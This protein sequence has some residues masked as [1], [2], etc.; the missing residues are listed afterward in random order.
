MFKIDVLTTRAALDAL[1]PEWSEMAE[2]SGRP[3]LSHQWFAAAA[4]AFAADGDLRIFLA[5]EGGAIR[6]AA[7]LVVDR[8]GGVKRLRLLGFQT[9]EPEALP[10]TDRAALDAVC[11]AALRGGC[12]VSLPRVTDP[13]TLQALQGAASRGVQITRPET[14]RTY[15][16]ILGGDPAALERAMAKKK[17]G[18]IRRR[19]KRLAEEFG[20]VGFHAESPDAAGA[21]AA[22]A[23]LLEAEAS[24]WKG[25]AGSSVL[26]DAAMGGFIT[27][28]ARRAAGA[29]LLR[30]F[31][32][33]VA[34]EVAAGHMMVE[35]GGKLWAIKLGAHQR[36]LRLGAGVMVTHEVLRW[37]C[38]HGLEAVDH[39]GVAETWQERWPL[40]AT[41]QS[42]FHFYPRTPAGAAALTVD[43]LAFAR[44]RLES[45]AEAR[46][47]AA[48]ASAGP[49][50]ELVPA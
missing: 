16:N 21:D 47:G 31:T 45:R 38:E 41:A 18:D 2:P 13:A 9:K 7:P 24:G 14:T 6:A 40:E 36:Y 17:L 23:G 34:G 20:E 26:D 28:Y 4:A 15:A 42:T 50:K 33:Q 5:R 25:R 27:D 8:K 30:V 48:G 39:L 10:F 22:L 44:R 29:G 1:A 3:L 32:L 43:A 49:V 19:R 12:P 11:R 37:A 46:R 35:G